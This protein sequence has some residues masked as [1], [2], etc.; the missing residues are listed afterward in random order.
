MCTHP[1]TGQRQLDTAAIPPGIQPK[2]ARIDEDGNSVEVDW[3]DHRS[4]YTATF[5]ASLA[6]PADTKPVPVLWDARQWE[7]TRPAVPFA[8]LTE[9]DIGELRRLLE[10]VA[11]YG[12]CFVTGTPPD[13]PAARRVAETI[14][15]VRTTLFGDMWTFQADMAHADTAYTNLEIKPHTDGTYMHD[16]PGLICLHCTQFKGSGGISILVDGRRVSEELRQTD[17]KAHAVLTRVQVP[18]QYIEKDVHLIARRPV[19]RI[20]EFGA[21]GQISYNNHDRAPFHL[22]EP[23]MTEFYRAL[24][25]FERL[26]RDPQLQFRFQLT[27]GNLVLFDNWRLLHGREAYQGTRKMLGCYLNHEDFESRFRTVVSR[28]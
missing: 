6:Y 11:E 2:S 22:P 24:S 19:L 20:D 14:G 13:L 16:A 21:L 7:K 23:E 9:G 4:R 8:G 18:G 5:L 28:P 15:Y 1:H 3:G 17:P 26:I 12:V 25:I 10:M 27:P